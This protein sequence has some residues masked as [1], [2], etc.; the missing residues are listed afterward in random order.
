MDQALLRVASAVTNC[1]HIS[2]N[3]SVMLVLEYSVDS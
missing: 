1:C 3:L 2:R